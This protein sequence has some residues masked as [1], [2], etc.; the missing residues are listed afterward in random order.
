MSDKD[1]SVGLA[2]IPQAGALLKK[3]L[4][5][6]LVESIEGKVKTVLHF[7]SI[8]KPINE[9]GFISA[10]GFFCKSSLSEINEN[11]AEITATTAKTDYEELMFPIPRIIR[12]KNLVYKAK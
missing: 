8:D 4:Y 6:I 7:I 9:N 2:S 12:I 1:F 5:L 3:P 11:Y 10:K